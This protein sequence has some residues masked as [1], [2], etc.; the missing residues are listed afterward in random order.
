[1]KRAVTLIL[2]IKFVLLSVS[3]LVEEPQYVVEAFDDPRPEIEIMTDVEY[4]AYL[5]KQNSTPIIVEAEI[6]WTKERIIKEIRETFPE[7]PDTAVAIAKCESGLIPD[8]QSKHILSYGQEESY[9]IMQIHARDHHDTAIAL[10][11]EDYKTDPADNLAVARH[12]KDRRGNWN[13]WMC[14]TKGLYKQYL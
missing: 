8:Q 10:G 3:L 9:G 11:F 6:D 7:D 13:D 4:A 14:Y 2:G 5:E 1:M 12:L